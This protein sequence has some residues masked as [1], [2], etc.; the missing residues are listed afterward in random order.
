MGHA[1]KPKK[2]YET[3]MHPWNKARIEDE[4][5]LARTYGTVNK[6]EIYKMT[7][8][9]K[10]A[11][12]QVKKL[13]PLTGAQA[14]KET[15]QLKQ[16]LVSIGLL[17][18]EQE[19]DDA[20]GIQLKDIM[21]RRL[22]T[23]VY[24]KGLSRSVKQARQFITHGHIMVNGNKTTSPSYIVK[25]ADEPTIQF[26]PTSDLTKEDHPERGNQQELKIKNNQEEKK[27][28]PK[29]DKKRRGR[30]RR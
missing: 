24:R 19:L 5:G 2:K 7:T 28:E 17:K 3:P 13:T 21:E 15:T 16:K 30:G 18:T 23:L 6:T 14:E 25:V 26:L 4:R 22:Q 10:R 20:L 11:K 1:K 27:R 12:D 8:L 29:K 9:L